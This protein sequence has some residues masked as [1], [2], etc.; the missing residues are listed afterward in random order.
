M[1][2]TKLKIRSI[3]KHLTVFTI[4][5]FISG[6]T[7]STELP[8]LNITPQKNASQKL[9]IGA[10]S[11]KGGQGVYQLAFNPEKN[12]LINTGLVANEHNPIYLTLNKKEQEFYTVIG[13]AQGGIAHYQFDEVKNKFKLS[14]RLVDINQGACHIALHPNA[15]Q[16]AVADYATGAISLFE[17]N[18]PTSNTS[19]TQTSI[20][21]LSS[22]Q[23]QGKGITAR[24]KG[25]HAHYVQWNNSGRFLYAT[26]LG[27]DEIL[28][29]TNTAEHQLSKVTVAAK[30]SAGD[31]P[32][33]MAF[34]PSKPLV[35]VMNELSNIVAVFQQ[36]QQTGMLT[37][38][39][40]I[41][42]LNIDTET[43]PETNQASAQTK[44]S[45]QLKANTASAIKISNDGQF[46]YAAIRGINK[47]AVFK[48]KERGTLEHIQLHSSLG[49]WPRDIT[50]SAQ[51]DHLFIANKLSNNITVLKRDVLS[52]MLSA[53]TMKANI[54]MP[55]YIGIF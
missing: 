55:A 14:T 45:A 48:V 39:Q 37:L 26:D 43:Q 11:K 5:F 10:F 4:I 1:I 20:S 8:S 49:N 7:V 24:Q 47:I 16:V 44:P 33:H 52:G 25:P 15:S 30:L 13:K 46:I 18:K 34:H 54:S 19:P 50:L 40:R 27:T 36:S 12:Q 29:F 2:T 3:I 31:G 35:Y 23:N 9:L 38:V 6:C 51:Q 21:L 41:S 42:A 28:L 53:T 22:Y 32:R 17:L